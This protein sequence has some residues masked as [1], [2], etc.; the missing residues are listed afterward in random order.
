V[1][2][3]AAPDEI[4]ALAAE[5]AE[6]RATKDFITADALRDRMT[7]AGWTVVDE[8]DG[9]WRLQPVAE[10][11]AAAHRVRPQD[12]QS[13]L[14]DP[15]TAEVSVQWVV[16]GWP[17]DVARG[18]ASF[19]ATA[20][21]RSVQYVVAD[22]TGEDPAA[23]GED[24][25]VLSLV[26][27]TGWAAARNAGLRRSRGRVVLAMDGSIEAVGDVMAPLVDALADDT[28][29]VCGPFG[30]VTT[31][32]RQF[33]EAT[34][35]ECDAVEGYCMAFRRETLVRAG[36]F[37]EKFKWYRTADIEYS[38]RIKDLGLRAVVVPA[39]VVRHDH[40]MWFNT[41]AAERARW[42]KRNYS[43][44]LDRFRG[45]FDLTLAGKPPPDQHDHH[46]VHELDDS[47]DR[48]DRPGP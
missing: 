40:R 28:V 24:V 16:E 42:S 30:I 36:F 46:D 14:D 15:A 26:E 3:D 23:F 47:T 11:P 9:A 1:T 2:A 31:D 45:R 25:E 13:V 19:R 29:G 10:A 27:K 32:L 43:L 39:P 8:P 22:V 12:V 17:E 21:D 37:D 44:F 20:G 38:F 35:P 34:G 7:E 5:R 33:D 41:P 18:I 48:A 6:A 4:R